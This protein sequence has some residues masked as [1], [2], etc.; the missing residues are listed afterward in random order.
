MPMALFTASI[1]PSVW[2]WKAE[3]IIRE[4]P[5]AR[6]RACQNAD[7]KTGSL[8]ETIDIGMPW[9]RTISAKNMCAT[10]FAV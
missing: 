3:L 10:D 2:G 6:N 7:E 5:D 1:C 4:E 9:S 8:S